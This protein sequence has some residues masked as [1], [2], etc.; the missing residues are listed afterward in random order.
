MIHSGRQLGTIPAQKLV[1]GISS[2]EILVGVAIL[3]MF[4]MIAI[5]YYLEYTTRLKV[6]S[7]LVLLKPVKQRVME[8]YLVNGAWP[9]NNQLAMLDDKESYNGNW[10]ASIEVGMVPVKGAITV[11]YDKAKLPELG[12]NNTIV[13]YPNSNGSSTNWACNEGSMVNPY[14]P[15]AC[16]K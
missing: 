15:S 12:D 8:E 6:E 1:R 2:L 4:A 14:R 3:S 5:P 13:Y 10:L 16:R 11:T 9:V 7:E